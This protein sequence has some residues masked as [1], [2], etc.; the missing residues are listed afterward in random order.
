MKDRGV[1]EDNLEKGRQIEYS[2]DRVSQLSGVKSGK[3]GY[4]GDQAAETF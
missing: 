3:R 4:A 1:A 2:L